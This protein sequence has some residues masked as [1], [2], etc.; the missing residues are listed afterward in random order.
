MRRMDGM[1]SLLTTRQLQDLLQ[2]DRITI[3][4]MLNDGRLEGFKVGGQ[5]RFSRHAIERW[6][7]DQQVSLAATGSSIAADELGPS[8]D[9]LPLSCIQAIQGIFA[10][11]M[12]I[13]TVTTAV[14]GIPL[15]TISNS[16]DF[17]NLILGT[18][19][20][21]QRCENSWRAAAMGPS[22]TSPQIAICHAG[23][24]FVWAP[25]AVRGVSVAA[26]HAGQFLRRPPG[27]DG[28]S[29]RIA[30][31]SAAIGVGADRLRRALAS[32]PVL[33]PSKQEQ[34]PRLL[35]RVVETF[36]EIGEERQNL[37]ERLQRIAEIT[38]Y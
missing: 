20:G 4:R 5:W 32:V 3:Y 2:V 34:V 10:E 7:Q 27:D 13:G 8:T 31:L 16:C 23:L 9:S 36:S 19:A 12:G 37:L 1:D 14:N 29:A 22:R 33:D 30:E 28:W 15:T 6:L 18:E 11:A 26:T 38:Q 17:C 35:L 24:N 21:Q 25:I